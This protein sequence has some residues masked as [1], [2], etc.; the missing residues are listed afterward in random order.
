MI[1]PP[2]M[3]FTP[4]G[5]YIVHRR[6]GGWGGSRIQIA[7]QVGLS[8]QGVGPA[9]AGMSRNGWLRGRRQGNRSYY[10]LTPK[11]KRLLEEGARRIFVRRT[12][13]WDGRWRVLTYSIPERRR[14]VRDDLR[15]QLTWMGFGPL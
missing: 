4:Y 11:S 3:L 14:E 2:S 5:G 6:G 7:A 9:P 10:S 1:R 12:G 8:A 15:K 13:A